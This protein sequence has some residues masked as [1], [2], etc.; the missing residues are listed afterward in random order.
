M[1]SYLLDANVLIALLM[2]EHE[3]HDRASRWL[4]GL[5]TKDRVALDPVVQGSFI[6]YAV[7]AGVGAQQAAAVVGAACRTGGWLFWPD[8]L[9]YS[10][11]DLATV[12]GHKQVTDTYLAMLAMR[13]K[14][15][16]VTFDAALAA[17]LPGLTIVPQ[18][19]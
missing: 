8:D 3:H 16:L 15:L 17:R 10:D 6:R 19:C 12:R 14:A 13:H 1:A 2:P 11:A 4:V 5:G 9:D 7:R 18:P